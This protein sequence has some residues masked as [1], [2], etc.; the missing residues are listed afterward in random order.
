MYFQEKQR[1]RKQMKSD[2]LKKKFSPSQIKNYFDCLDSKGGIV[3][4]R[5]PEYRRSW[6]KKT[7]V[8]VPKPVKSRSKS[9][10]KPKVKVSPKMKKL[11]EQRRKC[12]SLKPAGKFTG[13]VSRSLVKRRS[14]CK[15]RVS[16]KIKQLK[17]GSAKRKSTKR[18]S[19]KRKSTKRKSTKR[20]STKR[21]STKRKSTKRKS[22]GKHW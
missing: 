8:S 10:H 5:G 17:G 16:L 12:S 22:A 3:G 14:Q 13:F 4:K 1:V 19:T 20:K 18:K 21:K 7:Y 9:T 2:L 6:C 11:L 15:K